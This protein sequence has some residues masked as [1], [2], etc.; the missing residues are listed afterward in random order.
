L[1]HHLEDF[2]PGSPNL[3][4]SYAWTILDAPKRTRFLDQLELIQ[5]IGSTHQAELRQ[6]LVTW[7]AQAYL[8]VVAR[9]QQKA[10]QQALTVVPEPIRERLNQLLIA[11]FP[12]LAYVSA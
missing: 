6:N 12:A 1:S 4:I 2:S 3:A 9:V 10:A 8:L 11:T 7:G 5:H